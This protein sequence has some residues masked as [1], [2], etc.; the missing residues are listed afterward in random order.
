MQDC[1]KVMIA[2]DFPLLLEDLAEVINGQA[3]M[4]VVGTATNGKDIIRLAEKTE[5]DIILMDIEMENIIAGIQATEAIRNTDKDKKVIFLTAHETRDMIL[6]AMGTGAIDYIVKG[7]PDEEIFNHIRQAY[8]G[9]SLME[10]QIQELV[11][12]EYKRLQQS[13]R[14][15]LFFVNNLSELTRTERELITLL[16][17][18]KKVK[19]IASERSVEIVTVKSQINKL[20]KKLGV[21]RTKEIT[22]IINKLNLTHLFT[23]EV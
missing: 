10:G 19:E 17:K 2:E 18:G 23:K 6:T 4:K 20:L 11:L 16:L 22:K 7:I 9:Q 5:H 8:K 12:H 14:S 3:D 15:L 21:S 13:E 1:I